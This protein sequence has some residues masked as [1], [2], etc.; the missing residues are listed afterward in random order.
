M[1][2]KQFDDRFKFLSQFGFSSPNNKKDWIK[3]IFPESSTLERSDSNWN[4]D[5]LTCTGPVGYNIRILYAIA[6]FTGDL[7]K[8]VVGAQIEPIIDSWTFYNFAG[9]VTKPEKFLHI[10]NLSY[11]E[12]LPQAYLD[13][14]KTESQFFMPKL[15]NDVFY[16][17]S[18][19]LST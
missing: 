1:I 9:D 7:Q 6:G 14:I 15:P 13:A 2:F 18:H 19:L 11:Q 10:L 17:L 8:Y 16:P 12:I 4:A 5:K 3:V